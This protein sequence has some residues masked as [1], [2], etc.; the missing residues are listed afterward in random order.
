VLEMP[1]REGTRR[2]DV[3]TIQVRFTSRDLTAIDAQRRHLGSRTG[4]PV[5]RA[6]YCRSAIEQFPKLRI[7]AEYL[8]QL[9]EGSDGAA[10][11]EFA[12]AVLGRD[13]ESSRRGS[14]RNGA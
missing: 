1:R 7:M 11:Q 3:G 6:G 4:I 9:A 8:K 14:R 12:R 2:V 13:P 10:Y 5:S